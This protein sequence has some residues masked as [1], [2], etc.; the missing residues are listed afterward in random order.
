MKEKE[1]KSDVVNIP[2]GSIQWVCGL[3]ELDMFDIEDAEKVKKA[4]DEALYDLS[5]NLLDFIEVGFWQEPLTNKVLV[6]VEMRAYYKPFSI[7]I[8]NDGSVLK[9]RLNTSKL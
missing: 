2:Y 5:K 3:S 4:F 9:K 8:S 6:R 1:L 7:Y